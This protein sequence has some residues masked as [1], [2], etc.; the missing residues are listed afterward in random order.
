MRSNQAITGSQNS[1]IL[2]FRFSSRW[3]ILR[4]LKIKGD[5][6]KKG[7]GEDKRYMA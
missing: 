6:Q 1:D 2:Y 5:N 4:I 3:D 7:L